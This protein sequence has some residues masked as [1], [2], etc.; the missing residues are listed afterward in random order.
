MRQFA[1]ELGRTLEGHGVD[2]DI[3]EQAESKVAELFETTT[4]EETSVYERSV[5]SAFMR[6]RWDGGV[7]LLQG[8]VWR[9]RGGTYDGHRWKAG[10]ACR[11]AR[12]TASSRA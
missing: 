11:K 8:G 7:G 5:Y 9:D 1:M 10:G 6:E 3:Y 12:P 4:V 2:P